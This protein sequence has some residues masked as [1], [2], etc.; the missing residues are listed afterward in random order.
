MTDASVQHMTN[1]RVM[2]IADASVQHMAD[3]DAM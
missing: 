3:R 1:I 2:L